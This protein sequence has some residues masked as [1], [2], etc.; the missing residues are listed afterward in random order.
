MERKVLVQRIRKE[1]DDKFVIAGR[2]YSVI[3]A[4]ND[5]KLTERELQL[6]AFTAVR[7]NMSYANIR[8]DF[9]NVYGTSFATI[10]NMISRMKKIGV[11][12]KEGGKVKVA[13]AILLDFS[14]NIVLQV[15]LEYNEN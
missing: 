7:G 2:Y 5:L 14:N 8:Q 1:C 9:C 4:L 12:V 11:F 15:K 3:S 10:N 6:V 13:P